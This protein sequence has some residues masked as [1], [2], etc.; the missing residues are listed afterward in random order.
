MQWQI[1]GLSE[2]NPRLFVLRFRLLS[3]YTGTQTKTRQQATECNPGS[4]SLEILNSLL[5]CLGRLLTR[6]SPKVL[7]LAGL[8][9]LLL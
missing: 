2:Q 9:I 4:V 6:E 1:R 3:K 8:R 5:M 7:T